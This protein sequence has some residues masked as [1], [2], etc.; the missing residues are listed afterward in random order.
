MLNRRFVLCVVMQFW[1]MI[2]FNMTLPLIAQYVVYLGET[3]TMAGFVAGIFSFLALAMRPAS[4]FAADR[5]HNKLLLGIG[6]AASTIAFLGYAFSPNV[7]WIIFFRV[8]HAV[9]LCLQTTVMAV[10]AMQFIPEG[11]T[12]EGVGYI[13]VAAQLGFA[14]GPTVGVFMV[15]SFGYNM[16]FLLS[17][18]LMACTVFLL[19]PIPIAPPVEKERSSRISVRDFISVPAIPLA[20]AILAFSMC[21]GI[22]NALLV[23][24]GD[25]RGIANITIFFL[26]S[27]I[28]IAAIRPVAGRLVD[29]RG[30]GVL[31]PASFICET[32]C[33][34]FLAFAHSFGAAVAASIFRIFGQGTASS[35][36]QGQV[37]AD[38]GEEGRGVANSTSYIGM[39]IGQ[40]AGA[41]IGGALADVA[42]Y[43]ATFLLG[44][45]TLIAGVVGF[46]VW[47]RRNKAAAAARVA[48]E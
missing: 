3:T 34:V 24:L 1:F 16:T 44:P 14:I 20:T 18:I 7:G 4:G 48:A 19:L 22:T 41:I 45:V 15:D 42:G 23:L 40:G 5:V 11:R 35:S 39:D 9:G 17:A 47:R 25:V 8:V 37:L 26:I 2:A 6:F 43:E 12:V 38:A 10:I 36:L 28:G 30:L 27:S 32:V 31:L 46:L 21:S 29:R 33:M 13:G